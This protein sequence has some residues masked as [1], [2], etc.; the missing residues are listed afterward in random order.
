[1]N[2]RTMLPKPKHNAAAGYQGP[3]KTELLKGAGLLGIFGLN[4][5]ILGHLFTSFCIRIA[6]AELCLVLQNMRTH[7]NL[8]NQS[9]L[10][11]YSCYLFWGSLLLVVSVKEWEE[12]FALR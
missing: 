2:N 12:N 4:C 6:S 9:C 1:M 5:R 3:M 7:V 11:V 10:V 8:V